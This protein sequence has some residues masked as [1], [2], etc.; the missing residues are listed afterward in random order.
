[1]GMPIFSSSTRVASRA[2][3]PLVSDWPRAV[4]TALTAA[5]VRVELD[6]RPVPGGTSAQLRNTF[7]GSF[8]NGGVRIY[9]LVDVALAGAP[10]VIEEVGFFVPPP[11]PGSSLGVIQ[12]NH[13]LVDDKRLIYAVDRISG[14][15]YVLR[16]TGKEPLD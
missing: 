1:M 13:V 10:P 8:F 11:P 3:S 9:R 2:T 5:T 12:I 6:P 15:L 16:Y 7:V 4:L 14:G